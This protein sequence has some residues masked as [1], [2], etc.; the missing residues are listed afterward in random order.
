MYVH[1]PPPRWSFGLSLRITEYP[2]MVISWPETQ[3]VSHDSVI[4]AISHKL[5]VIVA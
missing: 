2:G 1:R 5:A 4:T 3:D